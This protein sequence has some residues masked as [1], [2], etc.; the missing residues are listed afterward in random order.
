MQRGNVRFANLHVLNAI[1]YVA[2]RGYK[3]WGLPPR[4]G[5]W[6]TIYNRMYRWSKK[7]V[8]G[9]VFEHLQR[10]QIVLIRLEAVSMDSTTV[11]VHPE[12]TGA[13]NKGTSVHRQ[14]P[15]RVDHQ[16]SYGCRGCSNSRNLLP[17]SRTGSRRPEGRK[18][19]SRLGPQHGSLSLLMDRAYE[20]RQLMLAL[21]FTPVVPPLSTRVKQTFGNT[22]GSCTRGSDSRRCTTVSVNRL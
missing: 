19:L 2:E 18:L 20:A 1:L 14:V 22:T 5:N 16:D 11:K 3:W 15:G 10:E 9:R 4:F 12:G 17:L 13:L 8:L 7:G 21:G 6:H